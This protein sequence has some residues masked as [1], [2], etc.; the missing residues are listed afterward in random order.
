MKPFTPAPQLTPFAD[1]QQIEEHYIRIADFIAQNS[2][3][4][5]YLVDYHQKRILYASEGFRFWLGLDLSQNNYLDYHFYLRHIPEKDIPIF[6]E[7]NR[8][9]LAFFNRLPLEERTSYTYSTDI[10]FL[11][12]NKLRLANQQFA[13]LLLD[14]NG[15]C[16]LAICVFSFSCWKN[17]GHFLAMRKGN[18]YYYEYS[19]EQHCWVPYERTQLNSLQHEILNLASQGFNVNEIGS[20]LCKSPETI[21]SAKKELFTKLGVH[22]MTSA[23]I[24]AMN[25]HIL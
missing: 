14:S 13:P 22:T 24:Y 16:R 8:A 9:C 18:P 6:Q 4:C 21:K 10:H 23:I 19:L 12:G 2:H 3:K 20:L 7:F 25:Y 1:Y 15:N 17:S 11:H 5:V